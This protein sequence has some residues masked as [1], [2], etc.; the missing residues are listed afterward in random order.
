M[1]TIYFILIALLAF[2]CGNDKSTNEQPST[3]LPT[4]PSNE[5]VESMAKRHIETRLSIPAT[6]KYTYKIY[7]AHLDGDSKIDAI[8]AVNRHEYALNEAAQ[9]NKTA[10]Q[11]EL[12]FVGNYNYIFYFD[13]GLNQISP[14]IVVPSNA[15]A[16][17]GVSF[18]NIHSEAYQDVLVDYHIINGSFRNFFTVENHTPYSFFQWKN[19]DGLTHG[20]SEAFYFEYA[21][22]TMT[23]INDILVKK[24]TYD[25]PSQQ[26]DEF[27]FEPTLKKTG[28]L[29][30]RF[31]YHPKM[32][33]FVTLDR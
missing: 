22:G 12:G 11:A 8:I 17:L 3:T 30:Y 14:E 16:P 7:K 19:F 27:T 18:A 24:A 23:L 26:V 29:A 6:E 25:Q 20:Y 2:S 4:K 31:F 13:G 28:K 9:S 5:T 1:K 32:K 21:P 33:K 10:K 15:A